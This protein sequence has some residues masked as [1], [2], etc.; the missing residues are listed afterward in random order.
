MNA[1]LPLAFALA[2]ETMFPSRISFF[3]RVPG[4]S[5]LPRPLPAEGPET[6]P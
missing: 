1:R 5:R 2:G 3:L 6:G 4:T